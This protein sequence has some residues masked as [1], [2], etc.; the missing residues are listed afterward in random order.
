MC[1]DEA[2]ALCSNCGLPQAGS[3]YEMNGNVACNNFFCC[4]AVCQVDTF[5]C[6]T[7][8]DDF[9]VQ[10]AEA[11]CCPQDCVSSATFLPPP[12]GKVDG[13]DLAALLA[14]WGPCAGC[15]ADSAN[16]A[17]DHMPDG[18]VDGADLAVLLVAWGNPGCP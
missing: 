12:D 14:S 15:C 2:F 3:C 17:F 10:L 13:A 18:V 7:T 9:C 16:S 6:A 8:W 11:M 4:S 1:V 5:C